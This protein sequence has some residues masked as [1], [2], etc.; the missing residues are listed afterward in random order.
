[1]ALRLESVSDLAVTACVAVPSAFVLGTA[2]GLL[3]L[4][5]ELGEPPSAEAQL[6]APYG[7]AEQ[8]LVVLDGRAALVRCTHALLLIALPSLATCWSMALGS[9]SNAL[10]S[11]RS[12]LRQS[13]DGRYSALSEPPEHFC[14]ADGTHV[15]LFELNGSAVSRRAAEAPAAYQSFELVCAAASLCWVGHF[16]LLALCGEYLALNPQTGGVTTLAAYP[17]GLRPIMAP[18][19]GGDALLHVGTTASAAAVCV[20]VELCCG[21]TA[22]RGASG[23]AR[24]PDDR[25]AVDEPQ[26]GGGRAADLQ[27]SSQLPLPQ[28]TL[29]FALCLPYL[30]SVC[31]G[32]S[33]IPARG[34]SSG[35]P[36]GSGSI[37][38]RGV[39]GVEAR[40]LLDSYDACAAELRLAAAPE[41]P[42]AQSPRS[43]GGVRVRLQLRPSGAAVRSVLSVRACGGEAAAVASEDGGCD[44]AEGRWGA[45]A[46]PSS[47][48]LSS[49]PASA[50]AAEGCEAA[51]PVVGH[52]RRPGEAVVVAGGRAYV[53]SR[54]PAAA[55]AL[56]ASELEGALCERRQLLC[57]LVRRG[58]DELEAAWRTWLHAGLAGRS[59]SRAIGRAAELQR[60]AAV[61]ASRHLVLPAEWDAECVR[62]VERAVF[63][64][65]GV[66]TDVYRTCHAQAD[67][68]YAAH[69]HALRSAGAEQLG[70]PAG[71]CARAG[72][73][74]F[75]TAVGLARRVPLGQSWR[76]QLCALADACE[77][78]CALAASLAGSP[79]GADELVPLF[80]LVLL[81][82]RIGHL[83][84]TLLLLADVQW[85]ESLGRCGYA[86]VTAQAALHLLAAAA[87][88]LAADAARQA[89]EER[90]A[91]EAAE[92][93]LVVGASAQAGSVGRMR[94]YAGA[95]LANPRGAGWHALR[96]LG[97]ALPAPSA[98][99]AH[100]V[101]AAASAMLGWLA[102]SAAARRARPRLA[103]PQVLLRASC[104]DERGVR[105]WLTLSTQSLCFASPCTSRPTDN[106]DGSADD[107]ACD[108]RACA[109]SRRTVLLDLVSIERIELSRFAGLLDSA[110]TFVAHDQRHTFANFLDRAAVRDAVDKQRQA[111]A[112]WCID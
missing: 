67:L 77:E 10:M 8:L 31:Q 40:H 100:A 91:R 86:L 41:R 36:S 73:E 52:G 42:R 26:P 55:G 76:E 50:D 45:P 16:V 65:Q 98:A 63:L 66:L 92:A 32:C 107:G 18:G 90:R 34:G 109:L 20:R 111:L 11:A 96:S 82:A 9:G 7:H 5:R 62:Q 14:V 2:D 94:E 78:T 29:A 46:W 106:G 24:A 54:E 85:E 83:P 110:L 27:V 22:D 49:Q 95:A 101:G 3:A 30:F 28:G 38:R 25:E 103:G 12:G 47:F 44:R 89:D 43:A 15:R 84:S 6:A 102:A 58:A 39:C 105:G 72:P 61:H 56:R 71:L 1:M 35:V 97:A 88:A 57:A 37:S 70:V 33:A 104:E 23:G 112:C 19:L 13:S 51:P 87:A 80:A 81:R 75:R 53:C 17:A 74:T 4:V 60:W 108:A 99:S 79:V 68:Q 69:L 93:R 48:W 59:A 64:W 21:G